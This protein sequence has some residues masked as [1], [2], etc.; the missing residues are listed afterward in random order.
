MFWQEVWAKCGSKSSDESCCFGKR[1]VH[2]VVLK[3]VM[4]PDVLARGVGLVGF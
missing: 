1:C 3:V 4:S 2:S